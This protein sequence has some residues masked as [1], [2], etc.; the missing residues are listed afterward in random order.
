MLIRIAWFLI[1][2]AA[3]PVSASITPFSMGLAL[4]S[5]LDR[6]V[7]PEISKVNNVP[8]ISARYSFDRVAAQLEYSQQQASSGAGSLRITTMSRLATLW[9]RYKYL[10]Y[11]SWNPFVGVGGGYYFDKVESKFEQSSNSRGGQRRVL[12]LGTGVGTPPL[13]ETLDLEGEMR[14]STIEQRSEPMFSF[15]LRLGVQI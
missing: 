11:T 13:W 8:Q 6:E 10:P 2:L 9:G 14:V 12:G 4:E 15:L 5:R 3:Q 1:L 7:N